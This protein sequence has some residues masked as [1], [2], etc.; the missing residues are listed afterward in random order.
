MNRPTGVTVAAVLT[1]CGAM[2]LALGS[3]AL[4]VV[5]VMVA[6]GED[7][8]EPVSVALTGMGLAGGFMLL[9]LAGA[10]GWMAMNADEL[11]E[12]ARTI[13]ISAT[14]ARIEEN[15]RGVLGAARRSRA[16]LVEYVSAHKSRGIEHHFRS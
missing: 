7:R 10:A 5:G 8:R 13:S 1:F 15:L 4:F 12:W 3:C 16:W 2:L 6:T 9:I 11:Y 14:G